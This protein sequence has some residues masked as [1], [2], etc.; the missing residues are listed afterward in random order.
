MEGAEE[1]EEEGG[2]EQEQVKDRE[3]V[4][5]AETNDKT[6]A[7]DSSEPGIEPAQIHGLRISLPSSPV[8][9]NSSTA[10]SPVFTHYRQLSQQSVG[11]AN[12]LSKARTDANRLS[13]GSIG[14]GANLSR[15]QSFGG[16]AGLT[17]TGSSGSITSIGSHDH[18]A[19][20]YSSDY[21]PYGYTG[22]LRGGTGESV[23]DYDSEGGGY[24]PV[25][26]RA[27]GNPLFPSN[28]ARLATGPTLIANNPSLRSSLLPPQ[29]KY[30]RVLYGRKNKFN[31]SGSNASGVSGATSNDYALTIGS[32]SSAVGETAG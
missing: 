9:S 18:A 24:D 1:E 28:F 27:P 4:D 8:I 19:Q 29:S 2:N 17:R 16:S 26:D 10:S 32:G 11:R 6:T 20:G 12:S 7:K 3:N 22:K 21:T 30:P 14:S 31:R 23:S 25:G 5:G 15:S 13:W